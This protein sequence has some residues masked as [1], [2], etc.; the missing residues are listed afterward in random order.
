[1]LLNSTEGVNALYPPYLYPYPYYYP[2]RSEMNMPEMDMEQMEQ[3][4]QMMMEHIETTKQIQQKVDM[5][6]EQLRRMEKHMK[7]QQI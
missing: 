3:M 2:R 4:Q 5:I 7:M 6:E 1:M